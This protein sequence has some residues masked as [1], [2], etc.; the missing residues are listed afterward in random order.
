MVE[1]RPVTSRRERSLFLT[2]PWRIYRGDPLWVPPLLSERAKTIDPQRGAFFKNGYAQLFLAWKDGKPAGTIAAAEDTAASA[3]KGYGECMIGFFECIPD[4][5]VAEA[6]LG[7]A[8]IWARAHGLI[9]LY[10]PYNLDIEDSRGVLVDGRDRPPALLCGH[11]P[12]YYPEYFE[13]FG[14]QKWNEDGLAYAIDIDLESPPIRRLM[15]LADRIRLRRPDITVRGADFTRVDREI[16][17]IRGLS[18]RS[19]AHLPGFV[20]YTFEGV[21][22]VIRPL[23][24][25]ADPELALFAEVGGEPAGFFPGVPN[26]NEVLIH[27]NGLR[28]PWDYLRFLRHRNDRP[29]AISVKSVL[30]PP[31]HWDTGV[32]VLLFD[33]L[34]RRAAAKG[35]LWADLSITGEDNTDTWPLAHHMDAKIYK[36]YRTYRKQIA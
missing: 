23:V 15:R 31:E 18:N 17:I 27:L 9:S 25:V 5:A 30:V 4:Y 8:E 26:L 34:A 21:A 28:R 13:C 20:P 33:E 32:G 19:L 10:G 12:P 16:E 7:A 3:F 2:F 11:N 22:A 24:S 29:K 35:Y 6:L 36:R 14:L 1:V